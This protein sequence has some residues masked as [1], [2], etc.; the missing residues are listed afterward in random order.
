MIC[1]A[2]VV[3]VSVPVLPVPLPVVAVSDRCLREAALA[4]VRT[5]LGVAE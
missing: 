5:G 1:D 3:L 4:V 2:A